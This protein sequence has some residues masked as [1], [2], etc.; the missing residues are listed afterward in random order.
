M[1]QE[2]MTQPS[3]QGKSK[4]QIKTDNTVH[5]QSTSPAQKEEELLKAHQVAMV[6]SESP[7][8]GHDQCENKRAML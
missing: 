7:P 8:G 1:R 5:C 2:K 3:T 4:P 6:S